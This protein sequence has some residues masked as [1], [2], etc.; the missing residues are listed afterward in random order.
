M[1]AFKESNNSLI[2][3]VFRH[4]TQQSKTR[5]IFYTSS[6]GDVDG[7]SELNKPYPNGEFV[8]FMP[9][10]CDNDRIITY[11]FGPSGAGKSTLAQKINALYEKLHIKSY[12]LSITN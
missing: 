1:L 4:N 10:S 5:I 11:I 8:P 9:L 2:V 3:G 12:I 6:D 7:D